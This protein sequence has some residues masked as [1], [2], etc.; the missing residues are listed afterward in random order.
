M[1]SVNSVNSLIRINSVNSVIRVNSVNSLNRINSV[2]SV[3]RVNTA[4]GLKCKHLICFRSFTELV[5]MGW[6]G[7]Y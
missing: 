3:N 4:K 2:N 6:E 1:N 5:W 7:S